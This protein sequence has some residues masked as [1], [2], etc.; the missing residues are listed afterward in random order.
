MTYDAAQNCSGNVQIDD[1]FVLA[2]DTIQFGV[3]SEV[4]AVFALS[5]RFEEKFDVLDAWKDIVTHRSCGDDRYVGGGTMETAFWRTITTDRW[6]SESVSGQ[7]PPA[8]GVQPLQASLMDTCQGLRADRNAMV[9]M[10][11]GTN[12]TVIACLDRKIIRTDERYI[13]LAPRASKVGDHVFILGDCPV[14]IY[15]RSVGKNDDNCYCALGHCYVHG[16]MAGEAVDM[17]L[18][19]TLVFIK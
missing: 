19:R 13:G 11:E 12:S 17:D 15:L 1:S 3:I 18:P 9:G 8:S 2:V 10:N 5:S 7:Q 6:H 14:P 16:I 4:G